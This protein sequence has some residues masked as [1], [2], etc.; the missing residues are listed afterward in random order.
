MKVA[1]VHDWLTGMRGGER[2]L[3]AFLEIYPSADIFALVHIPGTTSARI[4]SRVKGTS[5]L[6]RIPGIAKVY[7][8]LLPLFPF[9]AWSLQLKGYDLVISLSHAAAKNVRVPEGVPHICYCFTP[10]RYIWD[11]APVYFRGVMLYLAQPLLWPLRV[12]DRRGARR[13][14]EFVAISSFIA[15]RIRRFY[16]RRA[17]VIPPPVHAASD[18]PRTL[19]TEQLAI[20]NKRQEPFFLCAGALVPYKRIDVAIDACNTLQVPLWVV[21]KGPELEALKAKAGRTVQFFGHVSESFLW[22][23]YRRCRALLFPGV[24]DF[25]IVPVE[26]LA[27]GRPVIAVQAGGASETVDGVAVGTPRATLPR[28]MSGVF[29]PKSSLGSA[30]ALAQAIRYFSSIEPHF[31]AQDAR[32]NAQRFEYA[33]FFRTWRRFAG[34]VKIPL[35][36]LPAGLKEVTPADITATAVGER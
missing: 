15:A 33:V 4:D 36:D 10:M 19:T 34:Q 18:I 5:F 2:C 7:R 24:E 31:Q 32:E 16:G 35:G 21:G 22:E 20:L 25:G 14:T 13:V 17:V 1:I 30:E 9:A 26:C 8:G 23:S 6:N 12:W 29:L 11:Q 28:R 3:E 27:S